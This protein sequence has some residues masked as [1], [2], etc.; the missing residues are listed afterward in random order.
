MFIWHTDVEEDLRVNSYW[1]TCEFNPDRLPDHVDWE[2]FQKVF[3]VALGKISPKS[4]LSFK[5]G[6][7]CNVF[8]TVAQRT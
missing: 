6:E 7:Y 3:K 2:E 5:T 1:I 4:T 8:R